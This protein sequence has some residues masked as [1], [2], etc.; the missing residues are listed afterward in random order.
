MSKELD[1]DCPP[2]PSDRK[3]VAKKTAVKSERQIDPATGKPYKSGEVPA[4][5]NEPVE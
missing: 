4:G 3:A 1:K 5:E 2:E